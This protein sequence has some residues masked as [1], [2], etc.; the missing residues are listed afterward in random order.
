MM[1]DVPFSFSEL[2]TK[3]LK[4]KVIRALMVHGCSIH[5]GFGSPQKIGG[6]C[7][8]NFSE[9]LFKLSFFIYF[10]FSVISM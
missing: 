10:Y 4:E 1:V 9:L 6:K 3:I 7:L 8:F 5:L 2:P